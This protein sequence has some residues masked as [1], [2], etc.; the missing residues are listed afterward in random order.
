MKKALIL[1]SLIF[2]SALYAQGEAGSVSGTTVTMREIAPVWP[3]CEGVSLG[4]RD[5]CF[6]K[7]LISHITKNYKYPAAE[8]KNNVQGVVKITFVVNEKGLI[9]IVSLTGGNK[10]LQ[11][12]AK[13][14]I[15][16][17]PKMAEPGQ[18]GGEPHPI[19]YTVPFTF[20][21]GR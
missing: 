4:E 6:K 13:R 17:I 9:D 7:K 5:A 1:L 10:G 12:E 15:M 19:E 16:L 18:L 3:G 21:S 20:K 11:A 2:S 14:N 8:L